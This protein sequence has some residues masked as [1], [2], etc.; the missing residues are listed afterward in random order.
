MTSKWREYERRKAAWVA[1][2]PCATP[3]EYEAAMR[4]I[5]RELGL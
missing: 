3:E 2:H 4:E 5:A 1:A